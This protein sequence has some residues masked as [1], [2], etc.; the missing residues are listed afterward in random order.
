M[1]VLIVEDN[2]ETAESFGHYLQLLGHETI[3]ANTYIEAKN[4]A[5]KKDFDV[6]LIDWWLK[7]SEGGLE[8]IKWLRENGFNQPL[9]VISG[10]DTSHCSGIASRIEP[11]A[12]VIAVQKPVD[13]DKI[14]EKLRLM[15]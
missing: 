7:G 10:D 11:Y 5:L 8:I 12:R 15:L 1:R 6:A 4:L 3:L 13:S 14:I 9:A 2:P